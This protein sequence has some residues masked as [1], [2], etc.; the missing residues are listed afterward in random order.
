MCGHAG[1]KECWVDDMERRGTKAKLTKL[2]QNLP[3]GEE[4]KCS[5]QSHVY[6]AERT[7]ATC[8]GMLLPIKEAKVTGLLSEDAKL[9][10]KT[11]KSE[12]QSNG[13]KWN[14][15][16]EVTMVQAVTQWLQD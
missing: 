13:L 4:Q 6:V 12:L 11:E 16:T 3:E 2:P 7:V 10:Q 14:V 15:Q 5:K 1:R 9:V 8:K